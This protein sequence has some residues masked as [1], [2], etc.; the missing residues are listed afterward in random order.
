MVFV[1]FL[2]VVSASGQPSAPPPTTCSLPLSI[3]MIWKERLSLQLSL[4]FS[5]SFSLQ[6]SRSRNRNKNRSKSRISPKFGLFNGTVIV[7]NFR[8]LQTRLSIR[9]EANLTF[10]SFH[11]VLPPLTCF[12]LGTS[13]TFKLFLFLSPS[14]WLVVIFLCVS[15][16]CS[17]GNNGSASCGSIRGGCCSCCLARILSHNDYNYY[18]RHHCDIVL[19]ASMPMPVL[20]RLLVVLSSSMN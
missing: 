9:P 5:L 18:Y 2:I 19:A 17:R 4:S 8:P 10:S 20:A 11:F 15:Y 7:D 13:T 16:H 6:P 1:E 3:F 14:H 12:A